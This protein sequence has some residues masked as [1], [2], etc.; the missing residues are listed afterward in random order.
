[1][2][3]SLSLENFK[4]W[5]HIADMRLAP[6][7]GLFGSNSSGKTS[8]LQLLLMLKQTVESPDRRQVLNLGD[9]RSLVELGTIRDIIHDHAKAGRLGWKLSWALRDAWGIPDP[10]GGLLAILHKGDT[11]TY[12]C[13]IVEENTA[14]IHVETMSYLFSGREFRYERKGP[15]AYTLSVKGPSGF[16]LK[17]TPGHTRDLP[18]PVK[19]YG[20][21][22]QVKSYYENAG[23][24]TDLALE[25]AEL[26]SN[27]YYLGPLREYPKRQYSWIG[28]ETGDVGSRGERAIDALLSARQ[29]EEKI[30]R[31]KG[32]PRYT[33]EQYVAHWLTEL[34]LV[35][36]FR[37]K[38]LT[39]KDFL[40]QVFVRKTADASPVLITDVGFGIS[41]ILPV[42]VLCYYVQEGSTIILE[43]PETH[44]HPSVQAGLADV[45]IDAVQVREVQIIVES[46]SEHL[47]R[48]LQRR[49][50]EEKLQ[51]KDVALYFCEFRKNQSELVP[52][53]LDPLGNMRNWP[54][55]FFGDEFGEIA[56]MT[57]AQMQRRTPA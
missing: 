6:I 54:R 39:E 14:P 4:S 43:Q 7:T 13:A 11:L 19:C 57:R 33:L 2:L 52:L 38:R 41:Q 32:K 37:V 44:L 30:S 48:R 29:R 51:D 18:A 45:L 17:R 27:V 20:F 23:F 47:L 46:H 16:E 34:Q 9:Q 28:I 26:F 36:D 10:T 25:T 5:K 22:D 50:A 8:I 53:E 56:A 3:T 42:L 12:S 24:L 40:Y 1:M 15:N 35:H 31:G 21:P 55:D 49:I